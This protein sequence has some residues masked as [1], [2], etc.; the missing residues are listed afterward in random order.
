[1]E[2]VE[3]NNLL[4]I[5]GRAWHRIFRKLVYPGFRL[6]YAGV[7]DGFLFSMFI[8]PSYF[9]IRLGFF[10]LT[11]F[12]LFE[13]FLIIL[14]W[15]KAER[16]NEIL[17]MARKCPH[18]IYII[19]YLFIVTYTNLYHPSISTIF[20]WLMNGALAF[21][22]IAFL[23]INEY[24]AEG[25]LRRIRTY[26]W[27]LCLL[28]PLE[29]LLRRSPFSFLDTLGKSSTTLRFGTVRIMG[30]CTTANGYA[31][32]LC[33]LLP[34]ICYDIKRKRVDV[35]KN[36]WLVILLLLNVFLTGSRLSVGIGI[37]EVVLCLLAQDKKA[38][39]KFFLTIPIVLPIVAA[40][41]FL[42]RGVPF[43]NSILLAFFSAFDEIFNTSYSTNFGAD[44][45]ML[46]NSSHYRDLLVEGTFGGNWL[47]PLLGRGANYA[48][49]MYIDGY[50]IKSVDNF[51]VGQYITYAYPGLIAWL[52][53]SLTFVISAIRNLIKNHCALMWAALV[54]IVC[55]FISLWFL[56]QLQTFPIMFA[57]FGLVYAS[58]VLNRRERETA[59]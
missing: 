56:D 54:S 30:N 35:M 49:S 7:C 2:R 21:F 5:L 43:V 8:I 16:R 20:Y 11:A 6:S 48:F 44:A 4:E 45:T 28:S 15:K 47:N 50:Y 58:S 17:R 36:I 40:V 22:L 14:V 41:L 32:Y 34:F 53:M 23:I 37:L 51:Y 25:F 10:D 1:M 3:S 31:M 33:I 39:L 12:R 13:I 29:L 19:I 24:G 38:T 55:Y 59:L 42:L 27:I 18:T 26:T 46:Y 57:V 52:L 9:G